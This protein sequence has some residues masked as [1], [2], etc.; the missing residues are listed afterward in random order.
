M[1]KILKHF[2]STPGT[3]VRFGQDMKVPLHA[4][5]YYKINETHLITVGGMNYKSN[6]RSVQIYEAGK[7]W[8]WA[9]HGTTLRASCLV[10]LAEG[11]VLKLG[12]YRG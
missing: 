9:P 8:R 5:T 11:Q 1:G 3:F 12:G 2:N 10:N 6:Y 7:G 4:V